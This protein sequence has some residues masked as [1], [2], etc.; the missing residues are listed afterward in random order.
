MPAGPAAYLSLSSDGKNVA[1]GYGGDSLNRGSA[2]VYEFYPDSP[3]DNPSEKSLR[4]S[5]TTDGNPED[6]SWELKVDSEVK[7]KSGPLSGHKYTTFVEELCVPVESC[8]RFFVSDT[9]GDG[10][11]S[12]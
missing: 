4:I 7:L 9:K 3:C 1:V 11:S 6:T 10:V 2:R 8:V 5:F 12:L